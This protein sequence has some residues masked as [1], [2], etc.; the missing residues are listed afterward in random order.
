MNTPNRAENR[1]GRLLWYILPGLITAVIFFAVL[2][3]KGIYPFGSNLIDYY[4]MGQTNAPLYYHI[5]D[6]LHG[7]S[8]L[9]FDW[10]IN[11]G[12]N[13]AMASAIQWN[14]SP[15]NLFFLL[16][17]RDAVYPMLSVYM[18]LH[19][20]FMSFNMGV[21]L[22]QLFPRTSKAFYLT[23]AVSYGLCGYTLTHYTI[24]TYLDTA[25][26]IPI[27]ALCLIRLLKEGKKLPYI[28]ILGFMTAQSYYLSFMNLIDILLF[29]GVF[30]LFMLEGTGEKKR[31]AADLFIGTMSGILLS[32]PLLLPSV[33]QM[34]N[35]SRFNSNLSGGLRETLTSILNS[36]GADQYYVKYLQLYAMEL[37]ILLIISGIVILR[38]DRKK[39]AFMLLTAFIP[40][41]L[42]PFESINILWHFGTYYHYPI[43]CAY[44]IPFTLIAVA[45][46]SLE[47][48]S[49]G[50]KPGIRPPALAGAVVSGVIL[51][52]AMTFIY[53]KKPLWEIEE[54]FRAW[55]ITALIITVIMVITAFI[56]AY[57]G[58]STPEKTVSTACLILIPLTAAE[59]VFGAYA[60]YG[61]PRFKDRFFSDPEQS[62]EYI[63]K[64]EAFE[65]A[66]ADQ[67]RKAA[68]GEGAGSDSYYRINRIKNPDT[69][70]NANYGMVIR[71]GTVGGWA[72]TATAEQIKTA[73]KLGYSTHFMRILDSGGT[74]LTDSI[75]QIKKVVS[76]TD[77]TG[78]TE[79]IYAPEGE[80]PTNNGRYYMYS[81]TRPLPFIM[82][83]TDDMKDCRFEDN[84]VTE[85]NNLL[86]R[87]LGGEGG[88]IAAVYKASDLKNT[89]RYDNKDEGGSEAPGYGLDIVGKQAVYLYRGQAEEIWVNGRTV[90]VPTIGN[91][92]NTAYP[93]WF[94]SSLLL[95]GVYENETLEILCPEKSRL[96]TLDLEKLSALSK[97]LNEETTGGE[98]S[99]VT[100]GKTELTF[101][102]TGTDDRKTV[103]IPLSYSEGWK[104]T[105][106][107]K[108]VTPEDFNGLFM[109]L[110]IEDGDNYV[111][112]QFTPPGLISGLIIG[113][114]SLILILIFVYIK[115]L[116]QLGT[117]LLNKLEPVIYPAFC[118][119]AGAFALIL[120][121][122]PI[123]WFLIRFA[124]KLIF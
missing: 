22:K 46:Y 113:I 94:N 92:E 90:P 49:K 80:Y 42:I 41:A 45:A 95:L 55:V 20:F 84:S 44:L 62:G 85:N 60:G 6:F 43:R 69:D 93:A 47:M 39:A 57:I 71:K 77:I 23:A 82:T 114:L 100:A 15:F 76:E 35:S 122:I 101:N 26:F 21:F 64:A 87:I 83:I 19:L 56:V 34:R 27:L 116:A 74:F 65:E 30:I 53:Q 75:L 11:M 66:A 67:F 59:L 4:D 115:S 111:N 40:C 96:I 51:F 121:I 79:G 54:L 52:S 108:K 98:S 50:E 102:V 1:A 12:Q 5:W 123:I 25:V 106:N 38:K 33:L 78:E 14:I 17:P 70:L 10:Y 105:V 91:L 89:M 88:D 32:L 104:A 3:F 48:I 81:N 72:N 8:A 9:F 112:L 13:L 58:K 63:L 37:F 107:G 31:A 103:L 97:K 73:E 36:V 61:L 110:P 18:G 118:I 68:G 29:S 124:L 99:G 16:I 109:T 28:L 120:Y 86:Y 2:C 24:P 119:C 7:R 117:G